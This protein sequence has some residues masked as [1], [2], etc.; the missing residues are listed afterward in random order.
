MDVGSLSIHELHERYKS[1]QPTLT[2]C[3]HMPMVVHKLV[4]EIEPAPLV[5]RASKRFPKRL[6]CT[7]KKEAPVEAGAFNL[8]VIFSD[9]SFVRC[10]E[11]Q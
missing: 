3:A 5:I 8:I 11:L 6:A 9:W 4:P 2:Y 10:V 1:R 7:D